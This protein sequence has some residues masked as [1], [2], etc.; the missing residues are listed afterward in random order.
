MITTQGLSKRYGQTVAL[1]GVDLSVPEGS[2]GLLGENG[3]GKT[4]LIKLL[5][6]LLRPTAGSGQVFGKE[7]HP[8]KFR[9]PP[10]GGLYARGGLFAS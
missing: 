8:T 6:G 3:A 9:C 7:H 10:F 4:I 1:V 2:I 5:L